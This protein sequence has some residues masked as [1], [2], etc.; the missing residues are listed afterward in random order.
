MTA[1]NSLK[2]A[3]D[4][5]LIAYSEDII[6]DCE[7]ALL[8]QLSYSRDIYPHWDYNKFNLSLLDDAQC[9]TDLRY[10]KTDLPHL[11]N[12]FR[13]PDVIKCTQGTICR[14]MEAL[15]IML[16][17]LAFPCRYTDLA[18]TFGRNPTEICLIFNTVID[19]VYN[20]LSH[21]LLLWDQPMLQ[22]N[23]L[24][25]FADYIHGKG[26]PLDNCFGFIDGTVRRIA[27]PKTNQ[28]IVYNGHKRVHAL[29]FQS[30]V[31][32]NGMIANLA[33]PFEGKK[34]DSTM[35]CES[36]LLQQL[37]QFAWH[38]GRPLCLYGDPAYPIGVHLLAPYRSLNI[39]PDQHAFNKAMSA[40]RVSV[41]W[42]FG[43]MT[44]YFKFID[45][46]QSQKLGS[47]PIGKVYIVCSLIQNAHTCLYGNI[48]S[49]YFGL[50]APS[51]QEY[52]Q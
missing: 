46:K 49:D 33:G 28:R 48:V 34:H 1:L 17:R 18:N 13:L 32:P 7:F 5:L 36:G 52:F 9:W 27:R 2:T 26:A 31:V 22:S 38:D 15:C 51:L 37:Q 25:Q 29:K 16:K 14:G 43:L 21:K 47:S 45:F 19:H 40:H 4:S 6:D 8:Y 12:I 50:E 20:K 44:N 3:R 41:E 35:L 30:I 42:V 23:N 39:T 11:L 24:R 10:R